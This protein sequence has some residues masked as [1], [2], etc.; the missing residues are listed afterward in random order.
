MNISSPSDGPSGGSPQGAPFGAGFFDWVRGLGITRGNDRWFAGVAGGIAQ[1]AGIDPIIV[2]GL[3]VVLAIL[4]G[5]GIVLYL[6]GWL[7]LPDQGGKIH[8]EE[9]F[10]GR[11]GSAAVVATVAVGV[12]V[13][14]P[15]L[16]RFLGFGAMGLFNGW[17][18][19]NA[20]GFPH[21][22]SVTI[23]VFAWIA[24]LCGVGYFVSR[25]VLQRGRRVQQEAGPAQAADPHSP[26]APAANTGQATAAPSAPAAAAFVAGDTVTAPSA[27]FTAPT[28]EHT[29]PTAS[30]TDP[31]SA[32][33]ADAGAG[34]GAGTGAGTATGA[35]A[36]PLPPTD[37]T[38]RVN[39]ATQR[40]NETAQRATAKANDAAARA[41]KKATDWSNEVGKQADEW[42]ARYAAHHD[43]LKLGAAHVV[44][45]LALA[46]LAAGGSA[47]FAF[48]IQASP[49]LAW[50]AAIIGATSVLA[51]SLIVAGIRGRQTGGVGFL[52]ACGVIALFF[53]S[54]LPSGSQFQLFG[55]LDVDTQA[56]AAVLVAGNSTIDLT[57]L[58][59]RPS[60]ELTV[61][62]VAGRSTIDLPENEPVVLTVRMLAGSV[63]ASQVEP[64]GSNV[65]GP[66]L[67]RTIDTRA[68]RSVG[69]SR[70][71][72]NVL[73][74]SVRISGNGDTAARAEAEE[75]GREAAAEMSELRQ[76]LRDELAD[77][78]T[79]AQD[80][81]AELRDSSIS[82][83]RRERLENT[84]EFTRDEIASLEKELAR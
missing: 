56:P 70:V 42:S 10:R 14:L 31:T 66:F 57:Q 30:F 46:L 8:L 39:E 22:L 74:G 5:P 38:Q 63:D 76:E 15:V 72:V 53:T 62:Q 17:S 21:W 83:T 27:S 71:T 81:R 84:L 54:V 18:V 73:A 13:V 58:D 78:K 82:E 69:A 75:A 41:T 25:M 59:G 9:V 24:V 65:A 23:S 28:S 50:T 77:L 45:T 80:L 20:F 29:A 79:E 32:S 37:W 19:W 16:F 67:S 47:L 1:R 61:W 6:A 55:N 60:H 33:A 40:A 36:D 68:D 11:G 4:G 43:S 34:A 52:A 64:F 35:P 7:L 48:S 26:A 49:H 51:V 2:R 44:I 3:F 12:F